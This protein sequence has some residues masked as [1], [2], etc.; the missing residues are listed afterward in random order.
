MKFNPK[1][2][3]F[4]SKALFT[5]VGGAV[6]INP[7][8]AQEQSSE[9][10][11]EVIVT[12]LRGSL[13]ASMETKRDAIGV[14]DAINAEDIGKFPDTN[15]SEAL[16]RITGISID[17]RNGEG[18]TVT[19]RGF[20]PQ[21]NMVTLNGRQM[22]SANAFGGGDAITG[23]TAGNQRSFNFANLAAEAI[24]AVE[25]YKTGRADV[26]TGGI[27]ASINVRTARPF[28]NDGLVMNF[29]IKAVDD[30]TNRV[31]D[32]ITPEVS[33]IFSYAT[34]DKKFGIGL[35][36]SY[37]KRD[38]G[39]STSTV[40]DWHIQAW[41]AN[42]MQ[43][44]ID[45]GP[46]FAQSGVNPNDNGIVL[47]IDNAPA[48]GQLYGIPND[49]R[50]A[51]SDAERERTNAQLTLQFAPIETLTLTGDVTY[52]QQDITEDRGEQTIWLQR[53][54]FDHIEFDTGE[55]VATPVLL[56]E[57]TGSG[58]DFGY[59]QQ[60]REQKNDLVS[61]GFNASW[62]VAENFNLSFDFNDSRARSLPD[63]PTTG[64][65]ETLFSLAGKVP[66]A[67]LDSVPTP[68][69]ADVN[70][71]TCVNSTNFWTQTFQFNN[72]L[73]IAGRTLF[74]NQ[75]AAYGNTGGNS[76]YTFDSSSLGS[77]VLRINYRDQVTDIKQARI[78]GKF[79]F[80]GGSTFGFGVET[81][82]MES[83]ER[84]SGG[85]LALGDWGVGDAG[86]VP[87]MVALLTPFSLTGAFDD[88]N[89]V[90]AP[91]GGFKGNAN[92]LGQW[93]LDHG[94]TN[95]SESSAADGELRF[96][97]GFNTN[98]TV[99][100]DTQ[101]V[102]AQVALKFDLGSRASNLVIGARYEQTDVESSNLV[103]VPTAVS[104][105][106]DNDFR[107]E[108]PAAGN[109]TLLEG[110]NRYHNLLPNLDFDI[111]ITDS[112]KGRFSYSK[113]IARPGYDQLSEGITPNGPGG[114]T[115]LNGR[116]SGT[117]NNV[118]LL[119]LE[120][121]N[122]DLSIEY[123]FSD[124]GYVSAAA[125][126]KNVENFIGNSVQQ[127]PIYGIRDETAGPRAQAARAALLAAIPGGYPVND[128]SLFTMM[129]MIE[130]PGTF[131]YDSNND[132]VLEN[133]TGGVGQYN[134][135]DAQHRAFATQYDLLPNE[136]DPIWS[137]AVNTPVNNEDAKIHGFELGGQYFF[138]DTGFG[139]LANYTIVRGDIG[140]DVA[141]DP[142]ENQFALLGLSDSANA[143]LMFEKFGLSAR[144]AYNWRD[145]FLSN[146]NQGGFRN[147]IYVEAYDQIDLSV[148]YD[149]ND[150]LAVSFEAINLTGE[151]VRWHGRSD[152]Q[153]WRLEDQGARYGLGARYKF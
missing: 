87:D 144:L 32:D 48:D 27:G 22:P 39:S 153:L 137:F 146:I 105:Q 35:S 44:N 121:E 52:A 46:L 5:I 7:V 101:A 63:D 28:D 139:V 21:Y 53:N 113:T 93:A 86:S 74:P 132:G 68:T 43:N 26:A 118:N 1:A 114:P 142:N 30:T 133:Y 64:G 85:Y 12:G 97:P 117:Q 33:G 9:E 147:P 41:D 115:L 78:D 141:S 25:V 3:P 77:Q 84:A 106:D 71:T 79:D 2:L 135:S 4:T 102:Y 67:C 148:G 73:P 62:D 61:V 75:I 109:E 57:F 80:E 58:K 127:M 45:R 13:K 56:H 82:T 51:F 29:G 38:F 60:H 152:K 107:V 55:T 92:V 11:E 18:S 50:Y 136:D 14:V 94:Y 49:I 149:I 17:R 70:A 128:S 24:S 98:S 119:P 10:L 81:R 108:R 47:D 40:N 16:Q 65:S 88:F 72:G 96:N 100:E 42:N 69:D 124:K 99:G 83:R 150:H 122:F 59:E 134:G 131:Q 89:P 130:N 20:G 76:D 90:G 112:I 23:G 103:L 34:D 15:L 37:Q 120:S 19:A 91:T 31:G 36:A 8:F 151:D 111:A 140:Y 66:S 104:W 54:G 6:L 129:A 125:F 95:W 126:L 143:V 145:E 116:G 123:Y 138:G 110:S